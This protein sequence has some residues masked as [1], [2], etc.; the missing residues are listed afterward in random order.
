MFV[1]TH[2]FVPDP[3]KRCS[4]SNL[5]REVRLAAEGAGIPGRHY[6]HRWRHSLATEPIRAG[7]GVAQVQRH[8]GHASV[9]STMLYTH[10][11]V[12]DARE[13]LDAVFTLANGAGATTSEP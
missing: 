1:N 9:V 3:D 10:L 4:I 13:A 11:H 8:L 2:P 5:E 7:V 12:E 6:P